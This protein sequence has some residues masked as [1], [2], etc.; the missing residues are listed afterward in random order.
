MIESAAAV[1]D[2]AAT[3]VLRA[4]ALAAALVLVAAALQ[5]LRDWP[6]FRAAVA[7]YRLLPDAFTVPVALA[8]PAAELL[9]GVALMVEPLRILGAG[10]ASVVI[11]TSTAAVAINMLR[12][13][14][15]IDCGCGGIEGRQPLSWALVVR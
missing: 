5:K 11:G 8:V 14:T 6:S 7:D 15:H 12:G 9:A 3:L 2:L 10:L 1:V 4:F 13:R